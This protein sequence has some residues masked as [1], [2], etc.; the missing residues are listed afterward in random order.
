MS[1]NVDISKALA[2]QRKEYV[3]LREQAAALAKRYPRVTDVISSQCKILDNAIGCVDLALR[4][5]D[6]T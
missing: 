5:Y 2:D 3:R 4:A 1:E 6:H